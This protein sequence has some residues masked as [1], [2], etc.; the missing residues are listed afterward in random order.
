MGTVSNSLL[1]PVTVYSGSSASSSAGSSSGSGASASSGSSSA[2]GLFTGTSAYSADLQDVITRAV[3]IASLPME[4][5]QNQQ[6]FLQGQSSALTTL[7]TDFTNLQTA[8]QGIAT[9]MSGSSYQADVSDPSVASATLGDGATQGVYAIDVEDI[10]AYASSMTTK[11][12]DS[13]ETV[14]GAPDTYNLIIG[15]N[16]YKITGTDDSAASVASA[17]DAQYGNLVDAT[18]VNVGSDSDPD[19]RISLQSTTLGPM[20][21]D[22]QNSAGQGLQTGQ[23]VGRPALY[24]VDDS[25]NIVT[26]DSR[27]VTVS[28]GVSLSLLSSDP[29]T[30]AYVT[31]SQSPS[32]LDSAMS[33]F[34]T[35]YNQAV[36]DVDAQRGS[37]AG[38]LQAS[39]ILNELQEALAAISTYSTS[40]A[41][42]G[43]N[44][45]GLQLNDDGSI[46]YTEGT[47]LSA[48]IDNSSAVTSFLGSATGGGFLEAATNALNNLLDPS[49]GL[50]TGAQTD[51]QTQIT[52]LGGQIANDQTQ[53]SNLQTNL[54]N[55]MAAA[56]TSISMMQQQ[57]SEISGMF[58]AMQV[59]DQMYANS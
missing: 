53:I 27:T 23:T 42:S 41:V 50:L 34:T 43:L 13:T 48:D 26:S 56:D 39:P 19:Q 8:V 25:G 40:G 46:T 4:E 22:I 28:N 31:V 30:D 58:A 35:A 12:W 24:E 33:A 7:N 5:L 15:D 17:I 20:T 57:Y 21:L 49:A 32:A 29:G 55:Q 59:E 44:D 6:T 3:E 1:S 14:S 9:A 47:L 11:T 37:N 36:K 38:A 18:V 16:S 45:L 51:T 52:N 54:A 2:T 10:G